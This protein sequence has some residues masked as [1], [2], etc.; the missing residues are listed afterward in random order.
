MA[1]QNLDYSYYLSLF[2]CLH[3]W[4]L[5]LFLFFKKN[6]SIADQIL[7]LFLLG[8]SFIHV[9]HLVLQKGYLNEIPYLDP[10]MGIVLSALGPLFYFYVRA[11]T[12]ERELLKKSRPHWL[13]L[14]PSVINLIFL[15]L[16][17][18]AGEL[19]N[20]YYADTR[21]ETKY[22]LVNLL[23]LMG[24]T[25]Y[26]LFYLIAS[27]RVLN[28]HTAGIKASYSNVKRLQLGWLKD[29]IVILMVFSC[30]IAPV[31]IL[32]ADTKVSQL[33]IAYFSTFIYFIIVYKSLN[34]SV[35]FAPLALSEDLPLASEP[36]LP[37]PVTERYQ[38]SALSPAQVEEYG[39][40]IEIFL[41]SNKLLFDEDLSLRQMADVLKLSPHV[42]S[43]VINR[44]YNKSFFDLINSFRIEEAKKQL[45]NI[46]ELNITIEGIGYNCGFGSKTT[47]YRAFKKHTGHTP[48]GYVTQNSIT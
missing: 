34:Y 32:I 6:R 42:L 21:G 2:C 36:E 9:Q 16:T 44:Y 22:T 45:R 17:K 7:A 24:M 5:C 43:E 14:I 29:L 27:I 10:V 25:A 38:K 39:H 3:L 35:V 31:T 23:L 47:F 33:S 30:I 11:M 18:K 15:M 12:G 8:F 26:L 28:R 46:N 4:L 37:L 41:V 20:Y 48:T 1:I 13:I 19:H 40:T